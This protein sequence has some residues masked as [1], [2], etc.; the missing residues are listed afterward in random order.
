MS[1]PGTESQAQLSE[2]GLSPLVVHFHVCALEKLVSVG[3]TECTDCNVENDVAGGLGVPQG[4][5]VS[6]N[7][8]VLR[9]PSPP[10]IVEVSLIP[11]SVPTPKHFAMTRA[12]NG[13]HD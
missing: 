12:A 1:L 10:A 8:C 4:C 6:S 13:E 7:C 11:V 3:S 9:R 5:F 2:Q